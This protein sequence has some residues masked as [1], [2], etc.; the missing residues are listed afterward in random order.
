MLLVP[1]DG[2]RPNVGTGNESARAAWV[3]RMLARIPPGSR[4]LD[5]GAGERRFRRFCSHLEYVS[6]DFARYDG[7]GDGRGLQTGDW[8]RDDLDIVCDI[9]RIP[10]PDGSFDA[11]LC[12][13]VFEHLPQPLL[14]LWEFSRLLR[15]DGFL[16]LTAPFCSLTHFAPHHYYSGFN[17]YFFEIHLPTHG[18]EILHIEEN[19]DY[20]EYLA[21]EIRRLP[22]VA[23]RYAGDRPGRLEKFALNRALAMLDRFHR[24][25]SGS[26]E[27]LN[28]GFHVL[29]RKSG[30]M[31]KQEPDTE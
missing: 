31:E 7:K 29:A 10:E 6:Q 16:I 4:I 9:T 24:E 22:E 13:E 20:F 28:Y 12:T 30:K 15:F 14:G 8:S 11:I 23:A 5:A 3:E 18:F 25:D 27:L 1:E 21:Q 19:G 2:M 26:S 17:R